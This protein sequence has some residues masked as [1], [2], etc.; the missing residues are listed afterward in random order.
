MNTFTD[1]S[2]RSNSKKHSPLNSC[3][4]QFHEAIMM[5]IRRA[6]RWKA[7]VVK[8]QSTPQ[9]ME[10]KLKRASQKKCNGY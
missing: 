2:K 10:A 3:A 5:S 8:E 4:I 7:I 9:D 1:G 6:N